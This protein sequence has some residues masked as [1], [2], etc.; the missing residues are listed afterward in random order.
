MSRALNVKTNL[1]VLACDNHNKSMTSKLRWT[2]SRAWQSFYLFRAICFSKIPSTDF[3]NIYNFLQAAHLT[4]P[5]SSTACLKHNRR[6][7]RRQR[8]QVCRTLEDFIDLVIDASVVMF[9]TQCM[10]INFWKN[11]YNQNYPK[12][13]TLITTMV[14]VSL[15]ITYTL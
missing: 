3:T 6:M 12:F 8:Y 10:R 14:R 11:V 9:Q 1:M 13:T 5:S 7:S 2:S 4:S 15:T